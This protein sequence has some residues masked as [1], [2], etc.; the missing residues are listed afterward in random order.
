M[1]ESGRTKFIKQAEK[2]TNRAIRSI[3]LVGNLGN[4]ANYEYDDV[5]AEQIVTALQAAVENVRV[6]MNGAKAFRLHD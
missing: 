5:D 6:R 1:P 2:R 3:E 4:G